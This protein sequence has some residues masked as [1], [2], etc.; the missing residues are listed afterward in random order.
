MTL[1]ILRQFELLPFQAFAEFVYPSGGRRVQRKSP[2]EKQLSTC[3][4]FFKTKEFAV[5]FHSTPLANYSSNRKGINMGH[6]EPFPKGVSGNPGGR[7]RK[8]MVD[9]MLEELLTV[10]DSAASVTLSSR[11]PA[12]MSR[13][14]RGIP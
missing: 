3:H 1:D 8:P 9:R 13:S 6:L 2:M 14:A 12:V 7:K 4:L 10:D 5:E 11:C